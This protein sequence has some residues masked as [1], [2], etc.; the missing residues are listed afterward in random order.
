[1]YAPTV[2]RNRMKIVASRGQKPPKNIDF[3]DMKRQKNAKSTRTRTKFEHD[4]L[5]IK[6]RSVFSRFCAPTEGIFLVWRPWGGPHH[7][8]QVKFC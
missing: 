1:M 3:D 2:E 6:D 5:K 8:F 4:I 7:I